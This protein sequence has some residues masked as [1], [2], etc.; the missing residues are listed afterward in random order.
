MSR[1]HEQ[2]DVNELER[3]LARTLVALV[4][5]PREQLRISARLLAE[6]SGIPLRRVREVLDEWQLQTVTGDALFL[7]P[8]VL[9]QVR[10][11]AQ[12]PG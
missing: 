4:D 9:E 11:L 10:A 8:D 1:Q 12:G 5:A 2:L 6:T 7:T 3:L